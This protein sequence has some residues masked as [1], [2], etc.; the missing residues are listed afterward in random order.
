MYLRTWEGQPISTGKKDGKLKAVARGGWL[1]KKRNERKT[2]PRG[3]GGTQKETKP[4]RSDRKKSL[5]ANEPKIDKEM[6]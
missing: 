2:L 6:K 4:R 3:R 1:A 5:L